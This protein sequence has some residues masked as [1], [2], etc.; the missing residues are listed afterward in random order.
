MLARP[1]ADDCYSL[2]FHTVTSRQNS[3]APDAGHGVKTLMLTCL[4]V[5]KR[6]PIKKKKSL[7]A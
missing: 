5:P 1:C 2:W 4:A 7:A 3:R 6:R